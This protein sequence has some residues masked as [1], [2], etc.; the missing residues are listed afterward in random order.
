L[1]ARAFAALAAAALAAAFS[2]PARADALTVF[3]AASLREAVDEAARA[4][5]ARSGHRVRT[6]HGASSAL[7]RQIEAGAPADVFIAADTDWSEHLRRQGVARGAPRVIATNALVLVSPAKRPTSLRIAPG[8]A[9]ARALGDGRL[10]MGDPRAVPVGKYARAALEQL[11]VWAAVEGRI[12][13]SA[14][15]RAALAL[16]ARAEAP[17]GIV[18]RT[19]AAAESRVAIVDTFPAGS[20]API[21]YPALVMKAAPAAAEAFVAWMAEGEGREVFRRHGFGPP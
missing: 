7:A 12:A 14:D 16:V 6:V 10:A 3:A 4:F 19:D 8:F 15:A 17:L 2:F 9:L 5:Q 18:Y 11:G 21:V 13:P 20:H 1:R